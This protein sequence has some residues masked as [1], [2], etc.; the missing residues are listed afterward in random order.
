[1]SLLVSSPTDVQVTRE[2]NLHPK[3]DKIAV[4]SDGTIHLLWSSWP[5]D[6]GAG[7]ARSRDGAVTWEGGEFLTVWGWI[8]TITTDSDDNL[9]VIIASADWSV[10]ESWLMAR[11]GRVDKSGTTWTWTWEEP[12]RLIPSPP[13]YR[14]GFVGLAR[15]SRGFFHLVTSR[16]DAFSTEHPV[17]RVTVGIYYYRSSRP[18]DI[19]AINLVEEVHVLD[20][21]PIQI[22]GVDFALSGEA[23][24]TVDGADNVTIV[25]SDRALY[26]AGERDA[27]WV[28]PGARG[29]LFL[30]RY[31]REA[32][33]WEPEDEQ[34]LADGTYGGVDTVS[35]PDGTT[36]A[37]YTRVDSGSDYRVAWRQVFPDGTIG[38][39][40]Y[41]TQPD[42]A[43][44]E[45]SNFPSIALTD[46]G[47]VVVAFVDR[48]THPRG[49]MGVV[50]RPLGSGTFGCSLL[51][52]EGDEGNTNGNLFARQ[53]E[54]SMLMV[55]NVGADD[56]YHMRAIRFPV[57]ELLPACR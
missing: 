41:V 28:D 31:L 19:S 29:T 52:T 35:E 48:L 53:Y 56:E 36:H 55:Y 16:A 13:N 5:E 45:R 1:L 4:T 12:V 49:Q 38:P 3:Q 57:E 22:P 46:A 14:Q 34:I 44:A 2:N 26:Q 27:V 17:D 42:L 24:V 30:K 8:G 33:G 50:V 43:V 15:D 39:E 37:V 10:P 20:L 9:Y 54:D 47:D 7:Y 51:L 40:V 23:A 21:D 11:V 18:N 32:D 25:Y 6:G